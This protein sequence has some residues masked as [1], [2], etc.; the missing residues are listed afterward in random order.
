M[1][2]YDKEGN[3]AFRKYRPFNTKQKRTTLQI[4]WS[5]INANTYI[6]NDTLVSMIDSNVFLLADYA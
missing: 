2:K 6:E 5:M 4:F 1:V 3:Y